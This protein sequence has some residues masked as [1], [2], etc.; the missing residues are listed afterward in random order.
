MSSSNKNWATYISNL[1]IASLDKYYYLRIWH[2]VQH[3]LE[4]IAQQ[5][6]QQIAQHAAVAVAIAATVVIITATD[7]IHHHPILHRAAAM[8]LA[9]AQD[10]VGR[11]LVHL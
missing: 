9:E 5:A 8:D 11:E 10:H 3:Q 2:S 6:R 7:L 1:F 4:D